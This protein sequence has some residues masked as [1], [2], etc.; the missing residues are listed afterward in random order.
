MVRQMPGRGLLAPVTIRVLVPM[1]V[2]MF[3]VAM[4]MTGNVQMGTL[5]VITWL[6]NAS[7]RVRKRISHYQKRY[8]Q[9]GK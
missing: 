3:T 7:M 2:M 4:V 9:D 5:S 6:N 8:E 1:M